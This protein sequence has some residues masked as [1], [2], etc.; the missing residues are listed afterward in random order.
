MGTLK[1]MAGQLPRRM[2]F[3][4]ALACAGPLL[5]DAAESAASPA[6]LLGLDLDQLTR[7]TISGASKR[8]QQSAEIPAF[9]SVI[10][11]E[12][13]R[14]YGWTTLAEAL[15]SLPGVNVS[16]DR[17]YHAI[18]VRG[19]GRPG[20]YNARFLL[21]IDGL[22]LNDGIY[23]QAPIGED[24]PLDLA[25]VRRIEFVPGAGSVLFGGNAMLGVI[26]VVTRTGATLGRELDVSVGTA[27]A[28]GARASA[29]WRDDAGDT[30]LLSL[31]Q[32]RRA[33]KD[34]YFE[35]YAVPGT[36][37]WSRGLDHE[38]RDQVFAR[39][40]RGGFTATL[41]A[42][43]RVKGLPGG[44][45]GI[46]LD[47][48]GSEQIDRRVF[49][50]LRYELAV[51]ASTTLNLAGYEGSYRYRSTWMTAGL[52]EPDSADNLWRGGEANLTTTGLPAQTLLLGF[53]WREDRQRRMTNPTLDVDAPRR[54]I[55][56]FIQDDWEINPRITLSAGVRF[57]R[58]TPGIGHASPRLAL[59]LKPQTGTVI[60]AIT[61][62]AFRPP[63]AYETHYGFAGGNLPNPDLRH[64]YI[65]ASEVGVEHRFGDDS[66]VMGM[67]YR[68]RLSDL[69]VLET[70]PL[71]GVAQHRNVD[72]VE[73]RGAM[74]ETE[75]R[76]GDL[77]YAAAL[78]WQSVTLANGIPLANTPRQLARIRF[79]MP[80]PAALQLAWETR[81]TG[82][83]HAEAGTIQDLGTVQGGF[84]VSHLSLGGHLARSLA[85]QLRVGN[86]FNRRFGHVVG[87]EFN[88]AFPGAMVE[89]MSVMIQD[90]RT[91]AAR[92][93]V[94]F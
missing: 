50:S 1:I 37:A 80:L 26:N 52:V 93:F 76:H 77:R 86:V 44:P 73:M 19:F 25:L 72:A 10:D 89:P 48:T 91:F 88:A 56:M 13:I 12:E 21:L 90:G 8:P 43:E 35:A 62:S 85:W 38:G 46:D 39:Y 24:F 17:S 68:N 49:G 23:D 74:L 36:N 45:Y 33:G 42:G 71:T 31:T 61:G 64:E 3:L 6:G 69:I 92:L 65:H 40:A 27:A 58:D 84:A 82:R 60:K 41:L 59:L 30:W 5:A 28:R 54:A 66:R 32:A 2:G 83:R 53:A 22:P 78:S 29:G 81:Y 34:L 14:R 79:A 20:D 11:A 18:G 70:D 75:G 7:Q 67:L 16:Y 87:S 47:D 55:G 51:N 57:D 63:N 4:L 15:D 94:T 9:V